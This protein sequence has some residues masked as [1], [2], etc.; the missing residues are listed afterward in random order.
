MLEYANLTEQSHVPSAEG[1]QIAQ[2]GSPE[3][4]FWAALPA[5]GKEGKGAE[6]LKVSN[7]IA[8]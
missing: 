8:L 1:Y 7:L 5:G 3:A 6:E 2:Q 4:R